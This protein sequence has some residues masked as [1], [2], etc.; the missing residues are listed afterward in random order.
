MSKTVVR[1]FFDFLEGQEKWLNNMA[2]RGYRL[3]KCGK[4]TYTFDEC[5]PNEYEYAVEFVG[6]QAY[7][8]A[9]DYHKYLESMG[10]R[11]F[12]K[13][14]N[15][16]FSYGKIRWRPYAKGM[17]QIAAL[18][19]GFNKEL[20]ILE[21]KRDGKP[22]ELHTDIHDKRNLYKAVRRAYA[23]A[24]LMVALLSVMT[25]IPNAVSISAPMTWALRVVLLI[26][27][28]LFAV[29]TV[30]YSSLIQYLKEESKTF[31]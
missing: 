3:K 24:V 20:L 12:T 13:N 28:G 27:G 19:G 8:K 25:F 16:N 2:G 21:K 4:M 23:W 17:G 11:A 30:K 14:I 6:D 31:E 10:F 7:S 1:Y 9:K 5:E 26:F 22:F 29:P 18:P 15:L